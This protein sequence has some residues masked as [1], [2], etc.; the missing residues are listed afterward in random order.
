[1]SAEQLSKLG[2]KKNMIIGLFLILIIAVVS[3]LYGYFYRHQVSTATNA[4]ALTA[5]GTIEAKT[6]MASFK[7]PGKIAGIM[8]EEGSQVEKGQELAILDSREL[9]AKAAQAQ[10]AYDAAQGLAG[11]AAQGIP[12]TAQSVDAAIKQAQA[13]VAQAQ[14]GLTDAK[15]KYDR[16]KA[17]YEGGGASASVLDQATNSY[18]AAQGAYEA[19]RGKLN[20]AL[21]ARTKVDISSSQYDTAVGQTK[22]AQGAVEEAQAYLENTHLV[23]PISGFVTDQMLEIGEMLNAGTPVFELTDLKHTYVKVFIDEKKIGRVKLNQTASIKVDAYPDKVF[24][25]T[26]VWINDAGQ[27]AVHKAVNEQDDHDIRSFEVK[28]DIPNE[29]L[30][31]KTGMT[32]VVTIGAGENI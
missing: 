23:A 11:Q 7:V 5:T 31:L 21:A 24:Q 1:V 20:E 28:I 4:G 18:T 25:G 2:T 19:A 15:Q 32:A 26:V 6:V 13:L 29:S 27:F 12:L 10:G 14:S 9:A 8:V 3:I 16:T 22:Q 17:L 30:E